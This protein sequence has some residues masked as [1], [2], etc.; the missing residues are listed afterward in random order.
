MARCENCGKQNPN[1]A[2]FC[3]GCGTKID[4]DKIKQKQK[5]QTTIIV[6]IGLLCVIGVGVYYV[7]SNIIMKPATVESKGN[8]EV[9]SFSYSYDGAIYYLEQNAVYKREGNSNERTLIY[10]ASDLFSYE[11]YSENIHAFL[12]NDGRIY[13]AYPTNAGDAPVEKIISMNLEGEDIKE[14]LRIDADGVIW[15]VHTMYIEGGT[16][17]YTAGTMDGY[18]GCYKASLSGGEPELLWSMDQVWIDGEEGDWA[19]FETNHYFYYV[20]ETDIIQLD[21]TKKFEKVKIGKLPID[22]YPSQIFVVNGTVYLV[23]SNDG[24]LLFGKLDGN[25]VET[26]AQI[27]GEVYNIT[28]NYIYYVHQYTDAYY[29]YTDENGNDGCYTKDAYELWRCD[30]KGNQEQYSS[31]YADKIRNW[32]ILEDDTTSLIGSVDGSVMEEIVLD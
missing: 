20:D 4:Y 5:K 23:N 7:V 32:D 3:V 21:K 27:K 6:I 12:V 11:A 17:Y 29:H 10:N 19:R 15:I 28:P 14:H 26:I 16:L 1:G 9:N 25:T 24:K 13:I 31:Q 18:T 30:Y 22:V 2:T 8:G